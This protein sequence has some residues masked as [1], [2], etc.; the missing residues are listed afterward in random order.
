VKDVEKSR[1]GFGTSSSANEN[2]GL[3]TASDGIGAVKG[4][5]GLFAT[6]FGASDDAL[7]RAASALSLAAL[8][9]CSANFSAAARCAFSRSAISADGGATVGCGLTGAAGRAACA[10]L[11][12]GRGA[13]GAGFVTASVGPFISGPREVAP[14]ASDFAL[15]SSEMRGNSLVPM[16]SRS[17]QFRLSG[18]FEE[19]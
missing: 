15:N 17:R 14:V 12:A 18:P 9:R 8:T 2:F 7:L 10:G 13:I 1:C 19:L 16:P 5:E 11:G 6:G 3:L 4:D